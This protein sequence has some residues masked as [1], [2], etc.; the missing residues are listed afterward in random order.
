MASIGDRPN[1]K[2]CIDNTEEG[3][4]SEADRRQEEDLAD[5][6]ARADAGSDSDASSSFSELRGTCSV[7]FTSGS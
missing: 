7:Q 5:V 2:I 4:D 3:N 6:S 1:L